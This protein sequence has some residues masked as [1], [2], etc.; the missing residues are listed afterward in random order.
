MTVMRKTFLKMVGDHKQN[1]AQGERHL[2]Q[3][4]GLERESKMEIR[5][6]VE[7]ESEDRQSV[8]WLRSRDYWTGLFGHRLPQLR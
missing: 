1:S 3:P 2:S 4:L 6:N 5:R 8:G 7:R